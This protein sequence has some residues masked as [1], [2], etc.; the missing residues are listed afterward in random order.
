M[1]QIS[2]N[3][4]VVAPAK[5]LSFMFL[6]KKPLT[7]SLFF[8]RKSRYVGKVW[9]RS[10]L[11]KVDQSELR[12]LHVGGLKTAKEPEDAGKKTFPVRN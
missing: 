6:I 7:S 8:V 3:L 2:A 5:S 12:A 11:G 9:A 10:C 4:Y 1:R